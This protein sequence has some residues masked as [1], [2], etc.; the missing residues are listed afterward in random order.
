MKSG[1][2]WR[3]IGEKV[4]KVGKRGESWLKVVKSGEKRGKASPRLTSPH[5]T[6]L[7]V[8]TRSHKWLSGFMW[9]RVVLCG[10]MWLS[11]VMWLSGFKVVKSGFKV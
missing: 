4:R 2:N 5:L 11:G 8:A 10:F 7:Q 6:S 3:K 1:E 9:L